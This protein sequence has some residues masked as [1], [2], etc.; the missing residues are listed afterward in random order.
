MSAVDELKKV[1]K[2]GH[3]FLLFFFQLIRMEH[4]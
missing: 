4:S 2:K 3:Q 1:V